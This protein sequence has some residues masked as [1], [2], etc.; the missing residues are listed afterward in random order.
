MLVVRCI[1]FYFLYN[2]AGFWFG[3][4]GSLIGWM[5]YR[6]R[7]AYIRSWNFC[8]LFFARVLLNIRVDLQGK[9]HIPDEPCVIM[10]KH[11]SQWETFY[12]QTLF[13]YLC[14][15]LKKELLDIPFF[16]WGLKNLE[17]IAIDRSDPKQALKAIQRVGEQRIAQ[18]RKVLIFPEGTRIP[19]GQRGKYA[20]SG[21]SLAIASEVDVLPIAHNAG[22]CWPADGFIKY[23]G[24]ITVSI[25]RP[26]SVKN[27]TARE[28]TAEVEQWIETE[29]ERLALLKNRN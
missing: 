25:G 26:I 11:Q 7:S 8:A 24:T 10:A 15:I 18:G 16:G 14:T 9:E 12:L 29:C 13:P 4:T 5:P 19:Y 20:R 1:L 23:P 6:P 3:I 21:A 22:A 27:K 2:A 17:P 28:L